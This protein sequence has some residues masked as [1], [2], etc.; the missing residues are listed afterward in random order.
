MIQ[1]QPASPPIFKP[2]GVSSNTLSTSTKAPVN[3]KFFAVRRFTLH[4]AGR[5]S[6]GPSSRS[7]AL[8][9][10]ALGK[11]S[12]WRWRAHL[13]A[14]RWGSALPPVIS[15]STEAHK[16]PGQIDAY[17]PIGASLDAKRR[18]QL[19]S[20]YT[21]KGGVSPRLRIP[22]TYENML[23]VGHGQDIELKAAEGELMNILRSGT[24]AIPAAPFEIART[25]GYCSLHQPRR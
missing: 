5:I 10:E 11:V 1:L 23:L 17:F 15:V 12:Q 20:D 2:T 21:G 22:R 19:D 24:F 9:L 6:A 16:L 14:V 25:S 4:R 8:G 7:S 3:S 13:A 18:I